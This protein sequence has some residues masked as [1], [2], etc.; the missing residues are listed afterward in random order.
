MK[1]DNRYISEETLYEVNAWTIKVELYG[2]LMN[3]LTSKNKQIPK[4][5]LDTYYFCMNYLHYWK[6]KANKEYFKNIGR[7]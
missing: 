5:T 6:N 4:Q 3:E 2:I 7:S 1:R